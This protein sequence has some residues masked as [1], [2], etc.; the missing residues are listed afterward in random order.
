M[1]GKQRRTEAIKNGVP[2]V[3]NRAPARTIWKPLT[4]AEP[5][6]VAPKRVTMPEEPRRRCECQDREQRY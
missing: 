3:R 5:E 2:N 1:A 4:L 6:H